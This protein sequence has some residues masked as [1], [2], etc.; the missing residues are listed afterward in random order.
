MI[1]SYELHTVRERQQYAAYM[2]YHLKFNSAISR[3]P[4]NLSHGH[5]V[6]QSCR[7]SV[8]SSP[9]NSS[10]ARFFHTVISSH[11]QVVTLSSHHKPVWYKVTGRGPKIQWACRYEGSLPKLQYLG[12][13][14]P[15]LEIAGVNV[16]LIPPRIPHN[17]PQIFENFFIF[18]SQ[19]YGQQMEKKIG[20]SSVAYSRKFHLKIAKFQILLIL[21]LGDF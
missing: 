3:L 18:C 4:V 11:G 8:N 13:P 21:W 19:Q 20:K 17:S 10:Q 16:S 6:T 15:L 1:N 9:V 5:L 12:A 7:H 2:L 14:E